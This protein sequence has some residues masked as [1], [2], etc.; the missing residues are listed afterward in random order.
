M[1]QPRHRLG[2]EMIRRLVEEEHVRLLEQHATQRD[3][4]LLATRQPAHV[5]VGRRQPQRVHRHLDL[6]VE[7]PEVVRVDVLLELPL[8]LEQRRHLVVRHRLGELH[9][10]FVEAVERAAL[11]LE[12]LLDVAAH[13]LRLVELWLL[14]EETDLRPLVRPRLALKVLV[15]ACHDAQQRRLAR[16]VGAEDADLRAGIEREPDVLEDDTRGRND[17][18]QALHYIDELRRHRARYG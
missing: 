15:D 7:V 11:V 9:R 10:D 8:L 12:R 16:A 17:L 1:L 14:R 2:V 3:A 13:V 18:L 5:G 4:T 6:V